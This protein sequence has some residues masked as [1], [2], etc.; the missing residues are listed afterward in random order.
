MNVAG[1]EVATEGFTKEFDLR[2]TGEI[3]PKLVGGSESTYKCDYH[4]C[5][6]QSTDK[7]TLLVGGDAAYGGQAG[8]GGFGSGGGVGDAAS[9]VGFRSVVLAA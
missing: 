1:V 3:I 9:A 8:L 7:R 6:T 2:E 4:W 5:N